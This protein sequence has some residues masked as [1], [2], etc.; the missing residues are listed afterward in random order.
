M[1]FAT[2]LAIIIYH[3]LSRLSPMFSA[4]VAAESRNGALMQTLRVC[5]RQRLCLCSPPMGYAP[6]WTP[7]PKAS[8][9]RHP[10]PG[11]S[12]PG[13]RDK[14]RACPLTQPGGVPS[15]STPDQRRCAP[16]TPTSA[17]PRWTST[18]GALLPWNPAPEISLSGPLDDRLAVQ[19]RA[20][21]SRC[22][23]TSSSGASRGRTPPSHPVA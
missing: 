10:G 7:R 20:A 19:A 21:L 15:P 3:K 14:G 22:T 1:T 9:P 5:V 8:R 16:G 13:T 11:I 6:P 2:V 18:K 23:P 4:R 12:S 17:L